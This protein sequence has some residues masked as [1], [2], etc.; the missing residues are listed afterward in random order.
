M[1][2][3][4]NITFIKKRYK[5]ISRILSGTIIYLSASWRIN[6]PTLY[7][8]R[9]ALSGTICGISACKV[10]PRST[11]PSK[12]VS[13]YL[14][15]SSSPT[16]TKAKAGSYFLWHCLLVVANQPRYSRGAL[17]YAVRTF[18]HE[19]NHVDSLACSERQK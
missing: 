18:L 4:S 6:L 14:T 10:Y 15:F 3:C 16:F 11:L 5:P 7:L 8:G 1:V 2:A 17:L 9:A 13:S 12:A 19:I